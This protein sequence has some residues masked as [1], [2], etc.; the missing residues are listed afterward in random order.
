MSAIFTFL[1]IIA[2]QITKWLTIRFLVSG[3]SVEIIPRILSLTYVENRGAAFGILA[4]ARWFFIAVTALV[5]AALIV[6]GIIKKPVSKLYKISAPLIIA[7]A[8]G[9]LIDRVFRGFVVDMI[10]ATFIDF[11]VFNV[12]DCCVVIGSVLFCLYILKDN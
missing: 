2:D 1:M 6:Y 8:V 9:N 11:P 10:E 5:V 12:A 7:G 3:S 4:G